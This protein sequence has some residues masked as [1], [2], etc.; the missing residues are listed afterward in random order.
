MEFRLHTEGPV[1]ELICEGTMI[2][3]AQDAL[4]I[5]GGAGA[6]SIVVREDRLHPDFIHP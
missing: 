4:D 5:I 2:A 6:R 1:A 3:T